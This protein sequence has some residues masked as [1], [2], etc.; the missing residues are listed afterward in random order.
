MSDIPEQ[1]MSR[2]VVFTLDAGESIKSKLAG[3]ADKL[4]NYQIPAGREGKV[5]L[6]VQ[7]MEDDA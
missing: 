3:S 5:Q 4:L 7:V 6:Q 1:N 2:A